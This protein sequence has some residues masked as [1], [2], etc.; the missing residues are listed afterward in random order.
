MGDKTQLHGFYCYI[1]IG[2]IHVAPISL[3]LY[4]NRGDARESPI[5]V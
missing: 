2:A 4:Y 1:V 5:I 3:L